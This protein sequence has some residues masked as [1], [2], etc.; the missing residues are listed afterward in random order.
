MAHPTY[1]KGC[2]ISSEAADSVMDWGKVSTFSNHSSANRIVVPQAL[3]A[4][5]L[6][7]KRLARSKD[8]TMLPDEE[9]L[10]TS[11]LIPGYSDS[12]VR[13]CHGM[14]SDSSEFSSTALKA[15]RE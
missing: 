6:T 13:K 12:I 7:L 14:L 5:K 15:N 3:W 10:L 1:S 2:D 8:M 11:T 4:M 9:P